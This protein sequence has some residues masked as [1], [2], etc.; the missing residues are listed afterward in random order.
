MD[1]SSDCTASMNASGPS[2]MFYPQ[3]VEYV[4]SCS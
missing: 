3:L 1:V 2:I 4:S